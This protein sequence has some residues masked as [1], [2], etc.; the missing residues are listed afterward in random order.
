MDL[1]DDLIDVAAVFLGFVD[2]ECEFR[3]PA[4]G[5]PLGKLGTDESLCPVQ[6]FESG[7]GSGVFAEECAVDFG[8]AVVVGNLNVGD[9]DKTDVGV[10]DFKLDDVGDIL[11][12]NAFQPLLFDAAHRRLLHGYLLFHVSFD[13]IADFDVVVILNGDTAFVAVENFPGVILETLE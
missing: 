4:D 2:D 11:A 7:L 10:L 8:I 13:C 6:R 9:C 3:R 12:D 1:T 5:E